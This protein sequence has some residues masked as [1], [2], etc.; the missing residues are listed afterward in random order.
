MLNHPGV[1]PFFQLSGKDLKIFKFLP[2]KVLKNIGFS[3]FW[4]KSFPI[5]YDKNIF[6]K[7][8]DFNFLILLIYKLLDRIITKFWG[9][10]SFLKSIL[11]NVLK[12]LEKVRGMRYPKGG[13]KK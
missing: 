5:F 3:K 1:S 12:F 4:G 9:N 7:T 11:G 8:S 10:F 2:Q 6:L 13:N